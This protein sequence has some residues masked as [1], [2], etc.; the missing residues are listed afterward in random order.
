[1]SGSFFSMFTI[2]IPVKLIT[3]MSVPIYTSNETQ[4]HQ[5][6]LLS[7]AI[8]VYFSRNKLFV[9]FHNILK[10][11]RIFVVGECIQVCASLIL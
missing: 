4:F 11:L 3:I 2:G 10:L 8:I 6:H 9:L 7:I 5:Q 1:M